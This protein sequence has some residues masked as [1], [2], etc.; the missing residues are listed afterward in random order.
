MGLFDVSEESIKGLYQRA[1]T[2]SGHGFVDPRAFPDLDRELRAFAKINNCSYDE[3]Y[4]LA[5]T[6]KRTGSLLSDS[7]IM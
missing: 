7:P 5:K 4:T 3:A 2:D 6:G 1:L